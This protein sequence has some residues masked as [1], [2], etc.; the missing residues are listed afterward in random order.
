MKKTMT[1]LL[2]AAI[3][4]G[5]FGMTPAAAYDRDFV[6]RAGPPVSIR[7]VSPIHLGGQ[8]GS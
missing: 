8:G 6:A 5:M 1:G 3:T 7:P 2:A 4:A